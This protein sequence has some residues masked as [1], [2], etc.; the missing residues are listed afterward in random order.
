MTSYYAYNRHIGVTTGLEPQCGDRVTINGIRYHVVGVEPDRVDIELYTFPTT[1]TSYLLML[2]SMTEAQFDQWLE[3]LSYSQ[4]INWDDKY[5]RG[6]TREAQ[7]EAYQCTVDCGTL[8]W[9]T[10]GQKPQSLLD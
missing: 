9:P 2:H 6:D 8:R 10:T 5:R 7:L 3:S 4:L 1:L